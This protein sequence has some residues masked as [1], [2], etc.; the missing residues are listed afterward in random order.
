MKL[1]QKAT[2]IV[3]LIAGI[4][5]V[6][7]WSKDRELKSSTSNDVLETQSTPSIASEQLT[8]E[9]EEQQLKLQFL[10][11]KSHQ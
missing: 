6:Q 9:E 7:Q 10:S 8:P 3:L 1:F 11:C 5:V 2:I 4:V